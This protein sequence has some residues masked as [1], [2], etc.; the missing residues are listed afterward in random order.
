MNFFSPY[1]VY[2]IS[3]F[4]YLL[5]SNIFSRSKQRLKTLSTSMANTQGYATKLALNNLYMLGRNRGT[6]TLDKIEISF[7]GQ[8]K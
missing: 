4:V 7:Y 2:Q 5:C 8:E 3:F 6:P 1:L